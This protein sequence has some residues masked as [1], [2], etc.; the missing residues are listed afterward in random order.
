MKYKGREKR[1]KLDAEKSES[2]IFYGEK[3]RMSLN[4]E[5]KG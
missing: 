2:A 3:S 5:Q 1:P 4:S